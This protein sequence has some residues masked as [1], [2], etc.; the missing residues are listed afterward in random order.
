MGVET[1]TGRLPFELYRDLYKACEVMIR[2][3][4]FEEVN[5]LWTASANPSLCTSA[6]AREVL[7]SAAV[8]LREL[9]LLTVAEWLERDILESR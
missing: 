1:R 6:R 7:Q 4:Y 9:Q 8:T 3:H 5:W 2:A